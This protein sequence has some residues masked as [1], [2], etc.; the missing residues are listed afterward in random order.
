M[1]VTM[2]TLTQAGFLT[3]LV[4]LLP[5]PLQAEVRGPS[6]GG[7]TE[8]LPMTKAAPAVVVITATG[9][10]ME[11]R[12]QLRQTNGVTELT[13]SGKV[14]FSQAPTGTFGFIAPQPLGLAL[15]TQSPDLTLD[16]VAPGPSA[17]EVHKLA[18]GS[19]MLVGFVGPELV[20][21]LSSSE[22]PKNLRIALFSTLHDK[23]DHIAAIPLVKLMV[24]RMP[25][26]ADAKKPDSAVVLDMDLQS[27]ANR[28]SVPGPQ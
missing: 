14:L 26:R 9:S 3:C 27:T 20:A 15:V 10:E 25:M 7:K 4:C 6:P 8:V 5:T 23:A 19:G 24:D 28:R 1:T 16:P 21:P 18:D 22:R 13:A 17:Y 2:T 12:R 11:L